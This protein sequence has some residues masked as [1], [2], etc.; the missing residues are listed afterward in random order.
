MTLAR[1]TERT[2]RLRKL[3][4][5]IAR[6]RV[7][8]IR[9]FESEVSNTPTVGGV[10]DVRIRDI[11][12][13]DVRICDIR[14]RNVRICDIRIRDL[15]IDDIRIRN[16]WV[17][18]IR[19]RNVGVGDVRVR[20]VGV[21]DI[22][23]CYRRV[24]DFAVRDVRICDVRVRNI[25]ICDI[26]VGDIRIGDVRIGGI[27]VDRCCALQAAIDRSA[28]DSRNLG[29]VDTYARKLQRRRYEDSSG[30]RCPRQGDYVDKVRAIELS[31]GCG[32]AG[33]IGLAEASPRRVE[34]DHAEAIKRLLIGCV[35]RENRKCALDW[36]VVLGRIRQRLGVLFYA[37]HQTLSN[38]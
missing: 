6:T 34:R 33:V 2:D 31:E 16:V 30:D 25:W 24:V 23:I 29:N 13:R 14:I 7:A 35:P 22:R 15:H 10:R 18:N 19:I 4:G 28:A 27:W 38:T 32:C 17:G 20:D 12:I 21:G 36:C 9:E 11:R 5:C 26:R 1:V 8:F 37:D 3:L